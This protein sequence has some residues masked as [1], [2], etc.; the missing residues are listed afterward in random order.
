VS[1]LRASRPA[2]V[3]LRVLLALALI[4]AAA[5]ATLHW[6]SRSD[7][8]LRWALAQV[9]ARVPGQLTVTG[10]Q[11]ALARP[12]HI[13]RLEYVQDA[14][15]VRAS[16]I[17]LEWSPS[18]LA[19]GRRLWIRS[20][21]VDVIEIETRPGGEPATLPEALGLPLPIDAD[22]LQVGRLR[23]ASPASAVELENVDLEYAGDARFHTLRIA[24]LDSPWGSL[25][26]EAELLAQRPFTLNG[27]ATLRSSRWP[28]LPLAAQAE[29]TGTLSAITAS[30]SARVRDLPPV[31]AQLVLAPF[32]PVRLQHVDAVVEGLDLRQLAPAA[33]RTTLD[34]RVQG[35]GSPQGGLTGKVQAANRASGPLDREQ[36]PVAALAAGFE[37]RGET[38]ALRD[39]DIDLA[40]HATAK[41]EATLARESV[42]AR[43]T[44]GGLDLRALH[45]AL[46]STA[47]DGSVAVTRTAS[48][49]Q[50]ELDLAQAQMRVQARAAR[51]GDQLDVSALT[52]RIADGR[53]EGTGRMTLSGSRAFS[54]QARVEALDPAALGN[55][56]SA[57]LTGR[58]EARGQLAPSWLAHVTYALQRS[59]WRGRALSGEGRLTVS[60]GRVRDADLKMALA[61][62]RVALR[63]AFGHAGDTLQFRVQA[64]TLSALSVVVPDLAGA[65]DAQG[66]LGGSFAQPALDATLEGRGL[67]LPGG[68]RAQK[69]DATARLEPGEDPRIA[70]SAKAAQLTVGNTAMDAVQLQV[71]G[72]RSAHRIALQARRSALDVR[73]ELEGGLTPALQAWSGRLLALESR[74]AEPIRLLSAAPLAVSRERI[75]FG[76]AE[77]AGTHGRMRLDQSVVGAGRLSTSG[78]IT[79]LRLER[80]LELLDVKSPVDTDL[81]LG[82]RWNLTADREMNGRV[83]VFRE[84]GDVSA[85]VDDQRL[86]LGLSALSADI[87]IAGNRVT[88]SALA[89]AQQM[90]LTAQLETRLEKRQER[91]GLPGNAPLVGEARASVESIKPLVA[92]FT[93]A[94]VVDGKATMT[95][96]AKGTVAEPGLAGDLQGSGLRVEQVGSGLYLTDGTLA[97]QFDR[98]VI[99]L[100]ALT[101]RGGDGSVTANGEYDLRNAALKFNWSADRL[102]AVQR[103][104]LLLVASGS[105]T[106]AAAER[107]AQLRGKLRMDRGRVELRETGTRKLGDDVI[108]VGRK[109]PSPLPERV[110]KSQVDVTLDLGEDF[111]VTGRGLDA[112]VVGQVRLVTPGDAPLR[113]E[114]EIKVAK[115]T[116]EVYGRKLEIDPGALY[117]AGPLDNP[118]VEIRAMRRNQAVEAGVEVLGSARKLDVRLVSVPEV[119]DPEK[120]A[121]LTLGRKLDTTNQS[122]TETMQRYGAALATTIGTGSFQSKVARAVGLDEITVMP[123]TDA[124]TEGGIVQL[125]KR[126]GDDIYVILEQRLSTAENILKVNYQLT[127]DWAVRLESGTTDALDLF[128]TF[129]FD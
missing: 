91:W 77:L 6:A 93:R 22:R 55:F 105:G 119:P 76:P 41:G 107:R 3:L 61:G 63:G 123:G 56:P 100:Q 62:N 39:A 109:P 19:L 101:L 45:T 128:Y 95:V 75:A 70:V 57:R 67:V 87:R 80:T 127:R 8:V 74:G 79:A 83:E 24:R 71:D 44:V 88:A 7:A 116:F 126:V 58:A 10:M 102:T 21:Q 108:V 122:E 47:L 54:A 31:T 72:M 9:A 23:I 82:A 12:V 51:T 37:A 40:G 78:S 66:T 38:L 117:F 25:A 84:S 103:P 34:I 129:T 99:R 50:V 121:W 68:Y 43:L 29:F 94:A 5:A 16:G 85:V 28:D 97:V 18:V 42:Q 113:A 114:G 73:A 90:K 46:R 96:I 15:T 11:G 26:G 65:L 106:A 69:V 125:G 98:R 4:A 14:F 35:R 81:V 33:P 120:L 115:G 92:L 36:L 112:R 86:A 110:L 111:R 49:E 48:G 17:D 32:E 124:S 30:A 1:A 104:D 2:T 52:A 89:T 53:I 118:A 60:P 59:Q 20:L 27:N 13:D 64:P